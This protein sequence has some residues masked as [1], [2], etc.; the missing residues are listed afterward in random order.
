MRLELQP[1]IQAY[2]SKGY[3]NSIKVRLEYTAKGLNL[4]GFIFQFHKGAIGVLGQRGALSK[5]DIFQFHKGAIGVEVE[6]YAA[7]SQN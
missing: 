5:I 6:K 4:I 7:E 3:F 2:R 1:K